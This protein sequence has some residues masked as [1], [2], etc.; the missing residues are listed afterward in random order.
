[1]KR[2]L[3]IFKEITKY[4]I[5]RGEI[6]FSFLNTAASMEQLNSFN[7]QMGVGFSAIIWS[8]ICNFNKAIKKTSSFWNYLLDKHLILN[9]F[10]SMW[11]VS[12]LTCIVPTCI[13]PYKWPKMTIVIEKQK[14]SKIHES[15]W[16]KAQEIPSRLFVVH[17][18]IPQSGQNLL[19]YAIPKFLPQWWKRPNV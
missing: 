2:N 9:S 7:I 3:S 18:N 4:Y 11:F 13:V 8:R 10:C 14:S 17:Q 16:M 19:A 12:L 15:G 5:L 6:Q 1:M